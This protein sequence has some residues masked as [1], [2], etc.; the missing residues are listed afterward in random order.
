MDN[1]RWCGNKKTILLNKIII[2]IYFHSHFSACTDAQW[3]KIHAER[4]F[5]KL[6]NWFPRRNIVRL[7][8]SLT[9][10]RKCLFKILVQMILFYMTHNAQIWRCGLRALLIAIKVAYLPVWS[11]FQIRT[12]PCDKKLPRA[13]DS[14]KHFSFLA[15]DKRYVWQTLGRWLSKA[16]R[17]YRLLDLVLLFWLLSVSF[18]VRQ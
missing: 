6:K 4:V 8:T 16:M 17:P 18:E 3:I 12:A 9:I 2:T 1:G 13:E 7:I 14:R 10:K 15:T 11:K 5:G